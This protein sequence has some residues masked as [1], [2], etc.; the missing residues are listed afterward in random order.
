MKLKRIEITICEACLDGVPSECHTPGCALFLHTVD[1]PIAPEL[2]EVKAEYED[3]P[4][5]ETAKSLK[6]AYK[7]CS[8]C[9]LGEGEWMACEEPDCGELR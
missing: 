6:P 3:D 4:I 8:K 5:S 2:Y 1:L 7:H 9:G